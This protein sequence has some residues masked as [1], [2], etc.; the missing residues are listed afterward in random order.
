MKLESIVV[1]VDY[2]DFLSFSLPLNK[3]HFDNIIVVTAS[4]DKRT[5]KICEWHHVHCVISD[6][7][8]ADGASFNKGNMINEG[9]KRLK[10][11]D[12][13]AHIDADIV[14]TSQFRNLFQNID[15]DKDSIYSMDRLMVPDFESWIKFFMNPIV[16]N[17]SNIYLHCRP[18]PMGVRLSKLEYGGWICLGYLQ[19]WHTSKKLLYP[20]EHTTAARGD[21]AHSLVFPRS[22]RVLLG[23]TYCLHLD[24]GPVGMGANWNGRT[25]KEFCPYQLDPVGF[26]NEDGE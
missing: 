26:C 10:Y 12:W 3:Q 19:I 23:E 25:T 14:L 21:L 6:S 7:C 13:V 2:G 24:S 11:N 18:F 16:Q 4:H 5:Q 8:Y 1:C 22:K 15:L 17:E 9:L 20:T